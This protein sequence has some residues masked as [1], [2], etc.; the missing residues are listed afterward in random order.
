MFYILRRGT[1]V[2]FDEL[3]ERGRLVVCEDNACLL[4]RDVR[5][6]AGMLFLVIQRAFRTREESNKTNRNHRGDVPA[7]DHVRDTS[8]DVDTHWSVFVG[9]D[10]FKEYPF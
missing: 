6:A 7:R 1:F 10:L 9:E 4:L 3:H 8:V 2:L 5:I